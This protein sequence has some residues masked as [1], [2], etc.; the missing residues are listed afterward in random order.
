M[1]KK[2]SRA[3]REAGA[4][5]AAERAAEIRRQHEAKERRRRT[6]SVSVVVIGVLAALLAIGWAWQSSR[7][8]T[9]QATTP[10]AGVVDKYTL[11]YG[12]DAAPVTVTVYEDFMCPYCGEFEAASRSM[13]AKYVDQG[14]VQVRYHVLSFLDR[15]SNGTQYSTRSMNALGVVLDTAGPDVAKRFH[16]LLYENQPEEST[17]GLSDDQLVDLAV[18]AGADRGEVEGPIDSLKYQQWVVNATDAASKAGVTGTPT[19]AVDGKFLPSL[20]TDQLVAAVQQRIDA[21]LAQ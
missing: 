11:P 7:D 1:S 17:D 18:K 14:D 4:Q 9:G 12:A 2:Q 16:D 15:Y 3:V 8:T 6:I 19:V 21:K 20:S 10:P 5:R 13:F